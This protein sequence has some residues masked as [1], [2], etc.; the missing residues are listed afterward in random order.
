M[1]RICNYELFDFCMTKTWMTINMRNRFGRICRGTIPCGFL[2]QLISQLSFNTFL[3]EYQHSIYCHRGIPWFTFCHYEF[4]LSLYATYCHCNL[5]LL[6]SNTN[7]QSNIN[8][9]QL[10][11]KTITR[12][13]VHTHLNIPHI[14]YIY[15]IYKNTHIKEK[16]HQQFM[17]K[18]AELDFCC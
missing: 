18:V 13:D 1:I 2:N 16:Q 14:S 10:S 12:C 6:F 9:L 8:K 5:H 15:I 4:T 11:I 3:I 7:F 17:L